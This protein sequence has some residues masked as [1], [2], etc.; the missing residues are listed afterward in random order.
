MKRILAVI[1][2]LFFLTGCA[3]MN[4]IDKEKA[5]RI[6]MAITEV[7]AILGPPAARAVIHTRSEGQV[8]RYDYP[9]GTRVFFQRGRVFQ[10]TEPAE[11][12]ES[13]ET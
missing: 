6:G 8:I 7:V 1:L 9:D 2:I 13:E 3:G 4:A 5:I 11:T 10:I 12:G